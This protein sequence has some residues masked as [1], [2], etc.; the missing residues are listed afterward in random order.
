MKSAAI[1]EDDNDDEILTHSLN[2]SLTHSPRELALCDSR[3]DKIS[4]ICKL[5]LGFRYYLKIV[6]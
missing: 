5:D 6:E 2:N 1:T 3:I 4:L